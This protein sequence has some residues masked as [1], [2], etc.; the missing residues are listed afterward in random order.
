MLSGAADAPRRARMLA[1]VDAQLVSPYGVAMLGPPYTGMRDDVG[2]LTQKFPGAAENG[3]VYNHAAA[4]YLHGLYKAGEADRAWTVLRAMLPG[5]G[6]EGIVQR[7][8]LPVFVPNYYRGAWRLHPRTAGRSSQLFNTGTAAWMYR[9]LVE[10]LF[11]LRGDGQ[12]LRIAPQLPSHWPRARA[13]RRFRGADF[14]VEIERVAGR[15]GPRVAVDGRWLDGDAFTGI[16]AGR[17]YQ[18]RVEIPDGTRLA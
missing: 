1:A 16:E 7:G 2:R 15:T 11:G 13:W 14:E 4:F 18:V 9:C 17:C 10:E 5:P 12:A 8:Q 6:L 3:A